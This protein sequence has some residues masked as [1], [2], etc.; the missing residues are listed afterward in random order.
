MVRVSPSALSAASGELSELMFARRDFVRFQNGARKVRGFM[1]LPEG[2]VTRLPGTRF[3][4]FAH[5][6]RPARLTAFV[7]SDED[8]VLLE[9]TD[10]LLRFWRLGSLV[11][12]GMSPYT[13]ATPYS[14]ANLP[15]LRSLQSA[16]RVYLVDG[17]QPPQ[18]LSRFALTNWTIEATPF[19]GGPFAP[20]NID[21]AIEVSVSGVT[22]AVSLAASAALF[23]A[24]HIGTLFQLFEIDTSETPYWTADAPATVNDRAYYNSRAYRIVGFDG[25]RGLTGATQPVV[26]PGAPPTIANDNQLS[27]TWV[28]NGN[29]LSVPAWTPGA[30]LALGDRR[31]FATGNVTAEVSGILVAPSGS[32]TTGVNPPVH[33]EGRWLSEPGGPVW[34]ALHDGNGIVRITGVS[35]TTAATGTVEKRLPDG[36]VGTPTYRWA[37]QAWSATRGWPGAIGGYGQRHIYAGTPTEPRTFWTGVIGGTVDMTTGPNDDDGFSYILTALPKKTGRIVSVVEAADVLF[38]GTTADEQ[39]GRTTDADRAFARETAKFTS[40]SATGARRAEPVVIDG[41]PVFIDKS[42]TRLVVMAVDGNTGQ[43]RPDDLTTIARHILS[44]GAQRIVY[45]ARPVPVIWAALDDGQLAGLTYIPAQQVIGFHR[46]DLGGFVEDIEVLP[47]DDGTSEHLWLVI[48]RTLNGVTRR[49][50]ERMEHPFVDL[51]GAAPPPENAWHQMCAVRWQGAASTVIPGLGHLNGE[52]VTAWT[53]LGAVEGLTVAG[54]QVTLPRAVTSAIV[55]IDVTDTQ[56]FDSLDI[57]TGQPDGGDDGRLR[58]HRVSALRLHRTVAGTIQMVGIRDGKEE[59]L[60]PPRDIIRPEFNAPVS[61][62]DG[63]IEVPGMKGW[64]HQLFA[65][66]RP[67][68]GAPLTLTARTPTIMIT[69]D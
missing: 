63:V 30:L 20:R 12:S 46:H 56:Q 66:V 17:A 68:P 31:F 44:P 32:R 35:S 11:N 69:D 65:R 2:P 14:A 10:A 52:T 3:M 38:M 8:A 37:E 64:H 41:S 49:C 1:V 42:G 22:G 40:Q 4:G 34:E 60:D 51:N 45:Q 48:R 21:T 50:I 43:L 27:W 7:F 62:R 23:G 53:N 9:W 39:V 36:L 24:Q 5:L 13:I 19:K 25:Q 58:T 18:R 55:G 29:P 15:G 47:S 67:K 61:L 59:T 57:V 33:T 54:G 28:S 26:T 16:D 6:D